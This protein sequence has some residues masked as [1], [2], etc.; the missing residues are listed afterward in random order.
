MPNDK[1]KIDE[2]DDLGWAEEIIKDVPNV[3]DY[4][5]VKQGDKVVPGKDWMFG[6][7]AEWAIYG[8]VDLEEYEGEP[9]F[10]KDSTDEEFWQYWVHVDWVNKNGN[11]IWQN[12]YRVGPDYHD[13]KYYTPKPVKKKKIKE[14]EDNI[15][16]ITINDLKVG[17]SVIV[18]GYDSIHYKSWK[19][20]M[21][22]VVYDWNG[23]EGEP[24]NSFT[25][26]FN[27]WSNGHEGGGRIGSQNFN[28]CGQNGC[29]S[30]Y[31]DCDE[32]EEYGCRNIDQ[33]KF[34]TIDS[35]S[36]F[37]SLNESD[38]LGW[39]EDVVNQKV[40]YGDVLPYLDNDD[41][42]SVTGDFCDDDGKVLVS[43]KDAVFKVKK[44]S[45]KY[46]IRLYWVNNDRPKHWG[47]VTDNDDSVRMYPSTYEWD[48]DLMVKFLHKE[49][50]PF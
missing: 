34:Y 41:I 2:S 32:T 47:E 15:R 38:D 20:E 3:V 31:D 49:E 28:K 23:D 8:V 7:Q 27:N 10:I 42:I 39:A 25:I 1:S 36:L 45:Q 12:N 22:T 50:Y 43:V 29:W 13:L 44:E 21:G 48:K 18:N 40:R 30:F 17:M 37:D 16:E 9:R 24:G 33:I 35:Y 6:N 46:R 11:K 19:N 5:T 4:R 14:S 26:A